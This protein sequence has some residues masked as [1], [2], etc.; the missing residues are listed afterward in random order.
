MSTL[1][2]IGQEALRNPSRS[3]RRMPPDLHEL[4]K[5]FWR[6]EML[7]ALPMKASGA[8]ITDRIK[9]KGNP[10]PSEHPPQVY[11]TSTQQHLHHVLLNNHRRLARLPP[12]PPHRF[13][14]FPLPHHKRRNQ[15]RHR[16]RHSRRLPERWLHLP[17]QPRNPQASRAEN[18]RTV[19]GVLQAPAEPE[20]RSCVDNARG[21]SRICCSRTREGH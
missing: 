15:A 3:H 2:L 9:V 8:P 20:G 13:L 11:T 1:C 19:G 12:H 18:F 16:P 10:S 17:P 4:D 5:S 14:H 21:E 7:L 6:D